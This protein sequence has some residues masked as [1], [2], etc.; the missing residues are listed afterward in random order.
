MPAVTVAR[1]LHEN[2]L[3]LF[4]LKNSLKFLKKRTQLEILEMFIK[5]KTE[6]DIFFFKISNGFQSKWSA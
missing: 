2:L 1:I 3:K 5:M 4:F 6:L